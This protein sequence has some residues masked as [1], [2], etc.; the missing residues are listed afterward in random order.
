[1]HVS[2]MC[3]FIVIDGCHCV[4]ISVDYALVNGFVFTLCHHNYF[5][6]LHGKFLFLFVS[7]PPAASEADVCLV[8]SSNAEELVINWKVI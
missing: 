2:L 8:M 4:T 7:V 1:M 3:G 6:L 5:G